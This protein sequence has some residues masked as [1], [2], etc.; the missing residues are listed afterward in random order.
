MK[1]GVEKGGQ[2]ESC[3]SIFSTTED[4]LLCLEEKDAS[5]CAG[6]EEGGVGLGGLGQEGRG[7]ASLAGETGVGAFLR[8]P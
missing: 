4:V 8:S 3:Y 6:R 7:G 2:R 5:C 1:E